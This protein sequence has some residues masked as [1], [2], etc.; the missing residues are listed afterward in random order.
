MSEG[1]DRKGKEREN[2]KHATKKK[3]RFNL[4]LR[5]DV[6]AADYISELAYVTDLQPSSRCLLAH[7]MKRY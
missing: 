5:L 2:R 1:E 7:F 4:I 3:H 6:T